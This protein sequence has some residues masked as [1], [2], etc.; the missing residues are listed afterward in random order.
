MDNAA[1][2]GFRPDAYGNWQMNQQKQGLNS[3]LEYADAYNPVTNAITRQAAAGSLGA[4]NIGKSDALINYSRQG[5]MLHQ[6]ARA[7]QGLFGQGSF[8][9][10]AYGINMGIQTGGMMVGMGGGRSAITAGGGAA[11]DTMA[12]MMFDRLNEQMFSKQGYGIQSRTMGRDAT[13]IGRAMQVMANDGA[14]AGR[15]MF[16]FGEKSLSAR[17]R[18]S[19]RDL[20]GNNRLLEAREVEKI[21]SSGGSDS[22][23]LNAISATTKSLNAKG[24]DGFGK[25]ME[26]VINTSQGFTA[27]EKAIADGGKK[28]T[29]FFKL[30]GT[31]EDVYGDITEAQT[32]A[33]TRQLTGQGMGTNIGSLQAKL[34]TMKTNA[35]ALGI[36]HQQ[37][38]AA[39]ANSNSSFAQSGFGQ[40]G[41]KFGANAA[42]NAG[43]AAQQSRSY[44]GIMAGGGMYVPEVSME[45][46]A[47]REAAESAAMLN[48]PGMRRLAEARYRMVYD[49]SLTADDRSGINAA[50]MQLRGARTPQEEAAAEAALRG[51]TKGMGPIN[52][53]N[54]VLLS[55]LSNSTQ[56]D[57]FAIDMQEAVRTRVKGNNFLAAARNVSMNDKFKNFSAAGGGLLMQTLTS[58]FSNTTRDQLVEA[59][60]TGDSG[61]VNRILSEN[62][63]I[64]A[65]EG[66]S[67]ESVMNSFAKLSDSLGGAGNAGAALGM[68]IT[69][70]M[71]RGQ[72]TNLVSR[73][74]LEAQRQTAATEAIMQARSGGGRASKRGIAR[75]ILDSL[76]TGG[77]AQVSTN[78]VFD[79]VDAGGKNSQLI[80]TRGSG[81]FTISDAQARAFATNEGFMTSLGLSVGDVAGLTA[82]SNEDFNAVKLKEA[83]T[84][85]RYHMANSRSGKGI[86]V[87][88]DAQFRE[89]ETSLIR[90]A[91]AKV[92]NKLTGGTLSRKEVDLLSGGDPTAEGYAAAREKLGS[93]AASKYGSDLKALKRLARAGIVDGDESSSAAALAVLQGKIGGISEKDRNE[94]FR[95]FAS[96]NKEFLEKKIGR[97]IDA[98][99]KSGAIYGPV[100]D[101]L[102]GQEIGTTRAERS[103]DM[104]PMTVNGNLVIMG[105]LDS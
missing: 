80:A 14:F 22:Q 61:T 102:L 79:Y 29:D 104:G 58:T 16:T 57:A 89:H 84:A 23:M 62:G 71:Q 9:D 10:M 18:D 32:V 73:Q 47:A 83:L 105:K 42:L 77:G 78:Q 82:I 72:I 53:A 6:A 25:A 28:I 17:L 31:L 68:G 1:Q 56:G 45:A 96:D 7:A 94:F 39:V 48:T 98:D 11:A 101:L 24:Y 64:L 91:T 44:A 2:G 103:T 74:D 15:E 88:G 12:R 99:I 85:G 66:A 95:G 67:K 40:L 13:D 54:D 70:M 19:A 37:Y 30:M 60:R 21:I 8:V 87:L 3:L 36:G 92:Y 35:S 41:F 43:I 27:N 69:E 50:I 100:R 86:Q 75:T 49:K 20:R 46:A 51:A 90:D 26:S 65:Q 81:S 33:M 93:T 59:L 76:L 55:A 4:A 34:E 52:M 63:G 97:S 5:F 38:L